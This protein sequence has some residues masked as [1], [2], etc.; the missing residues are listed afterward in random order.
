MSCQVVGVVGQRPVRQVRR[1][2]D[3]G[4][5]SKRVVC[6]REGGGRHSSLTRFALIY[7]LDSGCSRKNVHICLV[8]STPRLVR[9][10]SHSAIGLSPGQVWP[11]PSIV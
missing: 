7:F 9:P 3:V 10:T 1:A 6:N 4:P 8:A 11:P 2:G 5:L